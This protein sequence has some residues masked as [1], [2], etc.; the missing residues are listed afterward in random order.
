M[1]TQLEELV[2]GLETYEKV[3]IEDRYLEIYS[4]LQ[5]SKNLVV[6]NLE[7]YEI[8]EKC[9]FKIKELLR[10]K[11]SNLNSIIRKKNKLTFEIVSSIIQRLELMRKNILK[12]A[13]ESNT[14]HFNSLGNSSL[15]NESTDSNTL[16]DLN[17]TYNT[18]NN[19][20]SNTQV[21]DS[22]VNTNT[23][24]STN[25]NI[26]ENSS[27]QPH[28]DNDNFLLSSNNIEISQTGKIAIL[29]DE[30]NLNLPFSKKIL[31][32][33]F[34]TSIY[35]ATLMYIPSI[36]D[37]NFQY[38]LGLKE[39]KEIYNPI[40]APRNQEN[41]D[42]QEILSKIVEYNSSK[43]TP[44]PS[45]LQE[46]DIV[47][48]DI[49]IQKPTEDKIK[50]EIKE[51]LQPSKSDYININHSINS[52]QTR[53]TQEES[54]ERLV[55]SQNSTHTKHNFKEFEEDVK[56]HSSL[57]REIPVEIEFEKHKSIEI[58]K[59]SLK[60]LANNSK[61]LLN[62]EE[63]KVDG[64]DSIKIYGE[65][66]EGKIDINLV[67]KSK[68]VEENTNFKDTK[69]YNNTFEVETF[70]EEDAILKVFDDEEINVSIVENS[71]NL[72]VLKVDLKNKNPSLHSHAHSFLF[73]KYF[74][75]A[76]FETILPQATMLVTSYRS[77][78]THLIPRFLDDTIFEFTGNPISNEELDMIQKQIYQTMADELKLESS[79][80][81]VQNNK[82]SKNEDNDNLK[83]QL[84][85]SNDSN[86]QIIETTTT[87]SSKKKA[88]YL[89]SSL[90]RYA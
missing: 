33:I 85:N 42:T 10:V 31:N 9:L 56:N 55:S 6:S 47:Y 34:E 63:E 26:E 13:F 16:N 18:N 8:L 81:N 39:S 58:E 37:I 88:Q 43:S 44:L 40:L 32:Y 69:L 25:T 19:K 51:H 90:R 49:Y 57:D 29:Y 46:E 86:Q 1:I 5:D 62:D 77:S 11:S 67:D 20:N 54:L 72:G 74:L 76:I 3:K 15:Y 14:S 50:D 24:I 73:S 83:S 45:K 65:E 38:H 70:E 27:I 2:F 87:H 41:I 61:N 23:N 35:E 21:I 36:K 22:S 79:S 78:Y 52:I 84:K 66:N 80:L 7:E 82:I 64:D 53:K 60:E 30:K 28:L 75:Q 89:L 17:N 4:L 48:N 68:N 12:N 59:K 71:K